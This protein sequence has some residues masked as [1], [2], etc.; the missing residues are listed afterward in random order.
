[1]NSTLAN[2]ILSEKEVCLI[3]SNKNKH[4]LYVNGYI[5]HFERRTNE[6]SVW[7]CAKR[8]IFNCKAR[9]KT[10]NENGEIK[11]LGETSH[12]HAPDPDEKEISFYKKNLKEKAK[13]T[14]LLPSQIINE[15]TLPSHI[16]YNNMPTENAIKMMIKR[17]RK[18]N[19]EAPK[20]L[21]DLKIPTEFKYIQGN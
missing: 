4:K 12:C 5:Y 21:E 19:Q 1:L 6:N 17:S 13:N 7:S 20:N 10:K 15:T 11:L 9:S 8:K 14:N 18:I 16:N 3:P 2:D